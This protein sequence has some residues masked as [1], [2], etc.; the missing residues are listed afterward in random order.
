MRTRVPIA[1]GLGLLLLAAGG[2]GAW[3]AM[4]PAAPDDTQAAE[5]L[6]I[7]PVPPRVA[8]GDRYEACLAL[9]PNDPHGAELLAAQWQTAGG[10]AGAEHCLALAR[11]A[12]GD[13]EEG[14][15]LLEQIAGGSAAPGAARAMVYDQAGQAWLMAGRA[16]RAFAA[17]TQATLLAPDNPDLRIDRALAAESLA[18]WQDAV[19]DLGLALAGD[20]RRPDALVLRGSA[21][22][23]LGQ[24]A[25]ARADVD[26][27]L[28]LDP[29]DPEAL[30]ERGILRQRGEDRSGARQDWERA[31]TLAPDSQTA[32]LARQN[33]ALLEAGPARH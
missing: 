22:R 5:P 25:Q 13:P 27:A 2:G 1:A 26:R 14:A 8:Q 19:D 11:I 4:R 28:A 33:L 7:P 10:G 31:I 18:R 23:Q 15:T 30:L 17:A 32:D 6:P 20:P 9:L 21:L 12:L 16:E 3:W 29:E 24:L